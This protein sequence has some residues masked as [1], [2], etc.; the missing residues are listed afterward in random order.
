MFVAVGV[1]GKMAS[2]T[3]GE[4]WTAVTGSTFDDRSQILGIAWNGTKFVAVGSS[5]MASSTDGVTWTAVASGF[6]TTTIQGVIWN[7]S[8]FVAFGNAKIALS[9]DGVSWNQVPE[10]NKPPGLTNTW[11][12]DIAWDGAQFAVVGYQGKM[13][14][15]ADGG[16][17][18]TAAGPSISSIF[19]TSQIYG[20]TWNG[21]IFLAVGRYGRMASSADGENWTPLTD[22]AFSSADTLSKVIYGNGKFVVVGNGLIAY[23]NTQE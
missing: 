8:T 1:G 17:H 2:S 9:A 20:I 19:G 3:N 6:G 11:L 5:G 23:S 22:S 7:G 16:E 13:F 14:R 12:Q 4:T 21:S 18:W 10:A 15:S